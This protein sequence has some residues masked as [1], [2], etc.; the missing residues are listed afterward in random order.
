MFR[1][2]LLCSVAALLLS[3]N[4]FAQT[5]DDSEIVVTATRLNQTAREAGTSVSVITAQDIERLGF[6]FAVDAI[7]SA[8]GVTVNANG[9]FGGQSAVRIRGASS[10]QTLVLIDGVAVNDAS[11]PGGGYDFARLDTANI[12]RIEILKGAQST[13]WGSDAIGGV[14]SI[15]TKSPKAGPSLSGFVEGGSYDTI[16]GGAA[17]GAAG[18]NGDFRLAVTGSN[19]DG[20]SK[21][22]E[23]QGNTERDGYESASVSAQGGLNLGAARLDARLLYTAADTEFDS[24]VFG[25]PGNVGDGDEVT[26]TEEL[27]GNV[28]LTL[29]TLQGR[30]NHL[31]L[32]GYS[33]IDRQSFTN[34][35]PGFT[36]R[37]ERT[38][39]RY[40]GTFSINAASTLAFGA[41]RDESASGDGDTSIDG[42]FALYK[43]KPV[44]ALT[45]TGGLRRDDHEQFGAETTAR[46]AAAYDVSDNVTLRATWG[47]GFKAPTIFQTTFFCCGASAPNSDLQP[48]TSEGF[49]VGLDYQSANGSLSF[50]ASYFD[51]DVENLIDFAFSIGGY[52]NVPGAS[53][54]GVELYGGYDISDW[55]T[56]DASYAYLDAVDNM[57]ADLARVPEHSGDIMLGFDT[58]G[59]L[60]GAVLL[61]Y[62]GEEIDAN[63]R[64]DEWV[65]AD[66]NAAYALND[67]VQIYGRVENIL[68]EDYQQV[69]GYG[70]AGRSGTVGL[71]LRY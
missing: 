49:D 43:L 30:L 38:T 68:D 62:N 37:G 67:Y 54:K 42:L 35:Q 53:R 19:S 12:A 70:T 58:G 14:V 33:E 36:A 61:R 9:G 27:S 41:E 17:F 22:D 52:A 24:F 47:Q 63:G 8:P 60:S 21:A 31:F 40:Q 29:P 16:R 3:P 55:I 15:T 10:E 51:Q 4:A 2:F 1:S 34:A 25:A 7:A 5:D 50:G 26:Q 57:G 39:Y 18:Q 23:A 64:V 46:I 65:R 56:I 48:E 45:L 59:P 69:L 13:L 20:I 66:I 6:A 11:S 32:L 71:R 28:T 44:D